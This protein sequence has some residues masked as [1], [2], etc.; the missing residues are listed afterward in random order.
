MIYIPPGVDTA[1]FPFHLA[2]AFTI[3]TITQWAIM[4][5]FEE[6]TVGPHGNARAIFD[7]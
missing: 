5:K 4:D 2:T 7:Q 1:R 6:L 3:R